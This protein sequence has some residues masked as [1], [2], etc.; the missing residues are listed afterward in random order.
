VHY[1]HS[2][3]NL[4]FKVVPLRPRPV[5]EE[6]IPN[7]REALI[8]LQ[9]PIDSLR[10]IKSDL[11]AYY[12]D[13]AGEDEEQRSRRYQISFWIKLITDRTAALEGLLLDKGSSRLV[14]RGLAE[15][16][17]DAIVGAAKILD[18]WINE[19]E[20][21][22]NVLHAI[23]TILAAADRIGL[24]AAAGTPVAPLARPNVS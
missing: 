18:R 14:A 10:S 20:T 3:A 21:F 6:A 11:E 24:G 16:A 1:P 12:W 23:G 17:S 4:R 22:P 7:A 5:A 9:A 13:H 2:P 8:D 15:E 19:D